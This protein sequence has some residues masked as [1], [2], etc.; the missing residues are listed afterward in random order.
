MGYEASGRDAL[1]KKERA[2]LMAKLG[3]LWFRC[4]NDVRG[5]EVEGTDVIIIVMRAGMNEVQYAIGQADRVDEM[6]RGSAFLDSPATEDLGEFS[7]CVT[8]HRQVRKR[9]KS[10]SYRVGLRAKP[11]YP[12]F[13]I[14]TQSTPGDGQ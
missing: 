13:P 6:K 2:T 11:W 14:E 4:S 9:K 1:T 8:L 7:V 3:Y 5:Y 12:I 10:A